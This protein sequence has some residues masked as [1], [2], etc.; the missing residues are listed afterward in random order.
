M[1]PL[2][3]LIRP[4]S[5]HLIPWPLLRAI[6]ASSL[7]HCQLISKSFTYFFCTLQC[8][9]KR[10]HVGFLL[11]CYAAFVTEFTLFTKVQLYWRL[12][13]P[14]YIVILSYLPLSEHLAKSLTS[15]HRLFVSLYTRS[16]KEKHNSF[17][18]L[19]LCSMSHNSWWCIVGI[20]IILLCVLV[21]QTK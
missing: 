17:I 21:F 18:H 8:K 14:C 3:S 16:N 15:W 13:L 19:Y 2:F 5:Y 1:V 10:L 6:W 11:L 4:L 20:Y 9:S 12:H 7:I